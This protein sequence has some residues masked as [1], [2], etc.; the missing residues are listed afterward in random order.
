MRLFL[1]LPTEMDL[2]LDPIHVEHSIDFRF[3]R[4][5]Y[6]FDEMDKYDFFRIGEENQARATRAAIQRYY[7][8]NP[9]SYFVVR[10]YDGEWIC[11]RV[12]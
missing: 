4:V 8:K 5:N 1:S 9:G 10:K 2:M 3:Y 6:P 11:R 7:D 12:I